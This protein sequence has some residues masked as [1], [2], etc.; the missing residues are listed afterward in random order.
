MSEYPYTKQELYTKLVGS[1]NSQQSRLVN[2]L[3]KNIKGLLIVLNQIKQ[4]G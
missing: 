1:L 4:N 3:Q 2:V